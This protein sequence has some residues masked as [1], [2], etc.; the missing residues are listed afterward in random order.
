MKVDSKNSSHYA[1][2]ARKPARVIAVYNIKGGVGKTST[3]VNLA[4]LASRHDGKVLLWDLDPQSASAYCLQIKSARRS[5]KL[6]KGKVAA[7]KAVTATDYDNLD[8]LCSD[9]SLRHADLLLSEM[10]KPEQQLA[11]IIA[12]LRSSYD[13]IIIDAPP[14]LTLL[15]EAIFKAADMVVLPTLPSILSLRMLAELIDFKKEHQIKQ[16]RIRAF[17]NMVDS[18]KSL[19]RRIIAER[20]R[21]GKVMLN[22]YI[23]YASAVEQMAERR[24]PLS[25]FSPQSPA[26][27]AYGILWAEVFD[28][29]Q[30]LK[31]NT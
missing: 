26:A 21:M 2:S 15:S 14:G 3:A 11:R 31:T 27:M 28:T 25:C 24:M 4:W 19:H 8:L 22:S 9:F 7:D 20:H 5:D 29:L 10:K 12:P 13:F 17:F 23:P 16:L 18:R 6:L 1:Y 30:V